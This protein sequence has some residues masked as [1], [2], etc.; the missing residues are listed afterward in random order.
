MVLRSSA[1]MLYPAVFH[2]FV[3]VDF[4]ELKDVQMIIAEAPS[5]QEGGL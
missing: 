4:A 3:I 2:Y 5:E 1:L